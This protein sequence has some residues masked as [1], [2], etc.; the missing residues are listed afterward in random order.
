MLK[1][2]PQLHGE[3]SLQAR[4]VFED[5]DQGCLLV[6][7][8]LPRLHPPLPPA[9][10]PRGV[11][12]DREVRGRAAHGACETAGGSELEAPL[13]Q[14]PGEVEAPGHQLVLLC[15]LIGAAGCQ[16]HAWPVEEL[17]A[18]VPEVPAD[19]LQAI[20]VLRQV[21]HVH[22]DAIR[23]PLDRGVAL[24][25]LYAHYLAI[26]VV[27]AQARIQERLHG[28]YLWVRRQELLRSAHLGVIPADVEACGVAA[29]MLDPLPAPVL[30]LP[31]VSS[32]R[33]GRH[34]LAHVLPELREVE[35]PR[36]SGHVRQGH[37]GVAELPCG[38]GSVILGAHPRVL[39][40][41]GRQVLTSEAY[42]LGPCVCCYQ[43]R[44]RRP[45]AGCA[46]SP[47]PQHSRC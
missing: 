35:R 28:H 42:G 9:P 30:A 39:R 1:H 38:G 27:L 29:L 14:R 10:P 17:H 6:S 34:S 31:V 41:A 20:L 21:D 25:L 22:V 13:L 32:G 23:H 8:G 37:R 5:E 33:L 36:R 47:S 43:G 7:T 40:A 24:V 3:V 15:R 26:G 45:S 19:R 11:P 44:A 2:A 4:V 12:H 16:V 46:A 18:V